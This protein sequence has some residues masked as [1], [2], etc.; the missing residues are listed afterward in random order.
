MQL[1]YQKHVPSSIVVAPETESEYTLFAVIF[2][3]VA[4]VTF[5]PTNGV[6]VPVAAFDKLVESE[7]TVFPLMLITGEILALAIPNTVPPVPLETNVLIA[8]PPTVSVL[9]VPAAPM[10]RPVMALSRNSRNGIIG[11]REYLQIH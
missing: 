3:V 1:K 9:A 4:A 7:N 2:A 10:F 8:F 6:I 11:H 5:I